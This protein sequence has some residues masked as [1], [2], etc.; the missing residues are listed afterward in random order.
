MVNYDLFIAYV[1]I[2][3]ISE[4]LSMRVVTKGNAAG[5]GLSVIASGAFLSFTIPPAANE[6]VIV[7][8]FV[9]GAARVAGRM[10]GALIE[11][12][13]NKRW[14]EKHRSQLAER[15]PR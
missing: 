8:L 5:A 3:A 9:A 1:A 12:S 2:G 6:Y 10:A 4:L 11:W 14:V 7:G 13:R 15:L